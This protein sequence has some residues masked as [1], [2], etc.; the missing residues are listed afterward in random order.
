[1][2]ETVRALQGLVP[3]LERG[4]GSVSAQ[5]KGGSLVIGSA[6]GLGLE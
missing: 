4:M 5:K 3:A 6:L 1:M 2:L